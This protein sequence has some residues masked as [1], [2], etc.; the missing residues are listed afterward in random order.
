MASLVIIHQARAQLSS[1][2]GQG[3]SRSLIVHLLYCP[4]RN[5][6]K[7]VRRDENEAVESGLCMY[8]C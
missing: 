5:M 7:T 3:A 1:R 2:F 4:K 8:D 6:F